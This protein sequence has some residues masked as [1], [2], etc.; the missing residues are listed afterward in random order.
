[1]WFKS[2][3]T[4][5]TNTDTNLSLKQAWTNCAPDVDRVRSGEQNLWDVPDFSGAQILPCEKG[6][7]IKSTN[8]QTNRQK[9][10]KL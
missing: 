9:N 10:E 1:M 8:S 2:Q 6:R 3:A 7:I 4:P 5:V